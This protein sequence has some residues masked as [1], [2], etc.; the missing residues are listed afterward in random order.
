MVCVRGASRAL[1][2]NH[3]N[4]PRC[5]IGLTADWR[6]RER[7]RTRASSASAAPAASTPLGFPQRGGTRKSHE[8]SRKTCRTQGP[9]KGSRCWRKANGPL[10]ASSSFVTFRAFFVSRDFG[11]TR[12]VGTWRRRRVKRSFEPGDDSAFPPPGLCRS[13]ATRKSHER[14]RKNC[15]PG[16]TH[17]TQ[18]F[19]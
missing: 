11:I 16:I 13:P 4:P 1:R 3:E 15:L 5:G 2:A 18:A 10:L 14:S 8:R 12:R 17:W 19:P 9:G 6:L 7:Q